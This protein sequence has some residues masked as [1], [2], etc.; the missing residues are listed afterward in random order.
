MRHHEHEP[1]IA[2]ACVCHAL[3]VRAAPLWPIVKASGRGRPTK[4]TQ[5]ADPERP[6]PPSLPSPHPFPLCP[7]RSPSQASSASSSGS[8]AMQTFHA[9]PASFLAP[10]APHLLP[11]G[12]P[13]LRGVCLSRA[14]SPY[15]ELLMITPWCLHQGV[16]RQRVLSLP[17]SPAGR[18]L[19]SRRPA[20]RAG[21]GGAPGLLRPVVSS[22]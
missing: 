5:P 7:V 1:S 18:A 12:A 17:R 11:P 8:A 3:A 6:L 21:A 19:A 16:Y 13:A 4:S 2:T 20:A 10:P 22:L 15:T 9:A 14:V